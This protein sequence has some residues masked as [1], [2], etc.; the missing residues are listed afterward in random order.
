MTA[1][2]ERPIP[3]ESSPEEWLVEQI[4]AF[5]LKHS[6]AFVD[7]QRKLDAAK[8]RRDRREIQLAREK[9][10]QEDAEQEAMREQIRQENEAEAAAIRE[11]A[12]GTCFCIH[13]G[14]C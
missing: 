12:C 1:V 8:F 11:Q 6:T 7:E 4:V 2:I 13:A 10:E 9:R 5:D 14:E 3:S